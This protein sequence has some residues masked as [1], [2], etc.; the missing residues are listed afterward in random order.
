[1]KLDVAYEFPHTDWNVA[2]I[3]DNVAKKLEK[4]FSYI[5]RIDSGPKSTGNPCN[6]YSPHMM[7]IKNSKTENYIVVSYWDR[8]QELF[9]GTC[10]WDVSKCKAIYTSSGVWGQALDL[11]KRYNIPIIPISYSQYRTSYD[12]MAQNSIP[13]EEKPNCDLLFRGFLYGDRKNL[14]NILKEYI[15]HIKL[16]SID[17]Y[18]ELQNNKINLSLNGAAEIC[19]RDIEILGARSV[20]LRPKLTQNFKNDLVDGI[21]YVGFE[22]SANEKEQAQ[23]IL[24]TF[25]NLK[26]S[27]KKIKEIS[28]NGYKWYLENGSAEKN[29]EIIISQ[30][31]ISKL[32]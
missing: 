10:G 32:L 7:T 5:R 13:V 31:D 9:Y 15:T 18:K 6:F 19:N 25:Q 16:D 27:P 21:H 8:A 20:L 17:Y 2:L 24:E 23:I 4:T 1:M 14:S 12:T 3:Y 30:L 26:N 28:E 11:S 29:A 22:Y